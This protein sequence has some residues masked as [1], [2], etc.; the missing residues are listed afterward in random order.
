MEKL[1]Y[2]RFGRDPDEKDRFMSVF[3]TT[4]L[5]NLLANQFLSEIGSNLWH[6]YRKTLCVN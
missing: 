6:K 3:N 4:A 5:L 2:M 1:H